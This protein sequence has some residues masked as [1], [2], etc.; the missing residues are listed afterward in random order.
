MLIALDI[1]TKKTIAEDTNRKALARKASAIAGPEGYCIREKTPA[2]I[3]LPKNWCTS[4]GEWW[5]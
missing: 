2:P 5:M 1:N 4:D 3:K